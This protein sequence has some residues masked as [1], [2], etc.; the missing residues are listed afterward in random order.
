[1][2]AAA[3]REAAE[4][5][6]KKRLLYVA[7]TRAERE[8]LFVGPPPEKLASANFGRLLKPWASAMPAELALRPAPPAMAVAPASA[9]DSAPAA[10]AAPPGP[11]G[12]AQAWPA[13]P[14]AR[15]PIAPGSRLQVTVSQLA[16]D[17]ESAAPVVHMTPPTRRTVRPDAT[18]VAPKL[19]AAVQGE[20]AHNILAR[21]GE[22]PAYAN[23]AAF[24]DDMLRRLG[25][26]PDDSRV[27]AV[28]RHVNTFLASPLGVKL[29]ALPDTGRRH[30]LPFQIAVPHGPH[31]VVLNGQLDLAFC[32][33]EGA[34]IVDFK[35]TTAGPHDAA[36]L[37]Q[38]DAY[39]WALS[40]LAG[41]LEPVRCY[42]VYLKDTSAPRLHMATIAR[43][44]AI[45]A[46][47]ETLASQLVHQASTGV[48]A[49]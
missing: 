46:R 21:L 24:V 20:I 12:Q 22:R 15:Q 23:D 1:V 14:P 4:T 9:T 44:A 38:L 37:R 10:H 41:T 11:P 39:A 17:A 30:E 34:A 45:A 36:Y 31:T 26:A 42:L 13:F 32:D 35:H 27:K 33:G 19:S 2:S 40:R 16:H 48:S 25:H 3:V 29:V 5:E 49:A 6:E 8:V 47:L 28:V 7:I 18:P 43:Q